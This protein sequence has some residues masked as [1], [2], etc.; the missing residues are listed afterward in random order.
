ML[1]AGGGDGKCSSH[2][3][4]ISWHSPGTDGIKVPGAVNAVQVQGPDMDIRTQNAFIRLTTYSP[5]VIRVR[6]S[7]RPLETTPS[8]AVI[9]SPTLASFKWEQDGETIHLHTDSL[10]IVVRK[11]PFSLS[12]FT[13][14]GRVINED[15]KGLG[16]SW[17]GQQVTTYKKLQEGERFIGLGEK[18]GNLDRAGNAYTNWN[19]DVYGYSV[20][21]DPLYSSIPFYI[22]IHHD[23]C[24]GLFLDNTYRTEFNFGAS[25]NR[26][27]SFGA[28]GGEMNYYF[29]YQ[30]DVAGLIKSYTALTGRMN[31]PPLWSLGYQQNRYSYYPD[32]EVLRIA[33]TLREKRIPADG[34]TLDI[35]YMDHYKLFTWDP[36]R[37]PH[38]E[39]LTS[40]L[41]QMGFKMT[42]IVDPGIKVEK[43]YEAYES[44]K[45]E[46]IFLK[47]PDG[48]Y[49]TGQVWP[50]WCH[51]PDFTSEKGRA[52]WRE[53]VR[54]FTDAGVAGIW[55][56]MNEISTWGQKMPD[57]VMFDLDGQSGTHLQ[58]HNVFGLEMARS[59][60]EGARAAMGKRP[61]I[62]SRSGYAGLQRYSA[63]WTG[64]NRAE[65]D[66]MLAGVRLLTSLGLSGVPFTGMDI[67]GFTGNPSQGLY[68]RWIQMG[69]FI[70]YF[71]NH[72]GHDS[73]SAEPWTFGE[74]ILDIA[75]RY[76]SLRYTLL[77]YIYSSFR[78]A[79]VDG[80]PVMR[81]L[82]IDYTHDQNIY[83]PRYQN[84]FLLG[85]SIL[86]MPED[87]NTTFAKVYLPEGEWY[88]AY[89]GE[90]AGENSS[91]N[92]H[93]RGQE[94]IIEL[95]PDR[96]PVFIRG[97]SIIPRQS[98]TQSTSQAPSDT[99]DLHIYQGHQAGNFLYYE[100][101]GET[102]DYEK[103][104]F[105]QRGLHFDPVR[106]LITLDKPEGGRPSQ[107]H[108][109]RLV[110][111]GFEAAKLG[112]TALATRNL[113][114]LPGDP[115]TSESV[116]ILI[117]ANDDQAMSLVY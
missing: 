68:T 41:G 47:Y 13:K 100:D 34:I 72:T 24:Y 105:Y 112:K 10:D 88:D 109:I 51:F 49:Y 98:V 25:N 19:S 3:A 18:T 32:S 39:T 67:G 12:F 74:D 63:I 62:L 52:W 37:F 29:I 1:H 73:K 26:F 7:E 60:Y 54:H 59:S 82:A 111:H 85:P 97:G 70:P 102:Y 28:Y 56:D 83:D 108:Y 23:L 90:K 46:D 115:A 64:D 50:G 66:H 76:I 65:D 95:S 15:E 92:T 9:S 2:T 94:K 40:R 20:S 58:G 21:Q 86:V 71:R 107:F 114:F 57:N 113:S 81:S 5:T 61:F 43:G 16:T 31:L 110:L 53:E 30:P 80:M 93:A 17:Q 101:D 55:N 116:R 27:S 42:V 69:A 44:G 77:P 35:H 14:D 45:K 96:L 99:L 103:G 87:C 48:Q 104:A 6:L 79:T 91:G 106:R 84:E 11:T 78:E 36:Q 117:M 8:Y 4:A 33:Q 75:R 38:P 89:T 22:G